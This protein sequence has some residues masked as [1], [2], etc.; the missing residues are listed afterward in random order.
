[1]VLALWLGDHVRATM[2]VQ[3][4]LEELIARFTRAGIPS[5]KVDAEWL[6]EDTLGWSRT[7]R[8]LEAEFSLSA[9][10]LE[11]LES[12]ALRREARE[13]LQW[14]LGSSEFYGLNLRVR[15]GVLIPRPETERLVELALERLRV[16]PGT[17]RVL[18]LGCGTGAIAL[19]IKSEQ[20]RAEV[21]ASDISPEAVKLTLENAARLDLEIEVI[22][23]SLFDGIEGKFDLIVSNPPYLPELDLEDL[24]PE[25]QCEPA[26]ALFSGHDGLDLARALVRIARERL[27]PGGWLCLELDP[28]NAPTMRQEL[29]DAGWRARLEADLTGRERFIVARPK[30]RA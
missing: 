13:P 24:E 14:I 15:A 17:P 6:L 9:K 18:D 2:T 7:R 29:E 22:Q 3:Q 10:Q 20:P 25:V 8:V 27:G 16:I 23:T 26:S 21:I 28:R 12:W 30:S 11:H 5:P 4:K 19:C 1:V